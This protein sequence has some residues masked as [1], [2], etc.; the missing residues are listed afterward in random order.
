MRP[1]SHKDQ[2]SRQVLHL[3]NKCCQL[4]LDAIGMRFI[5]CYY[6]IG[7]PSGVFG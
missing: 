1:V 3:I 6:M 5:V 7:L 2:Q 4:S